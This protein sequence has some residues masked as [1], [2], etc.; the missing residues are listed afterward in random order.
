MARTERSGAVGVGGVIPDDVRVRRAPAGAD[1]ALNHSDVRLAGGIL[2]V[3][4]FLDQS[5][6]IAIGD[7]PPAQQP[8]PPEIVAPFGIGI[9]AAPHHRGGGAPRGEQRR[10]AVQTIEQP[11]H[12][13]RGREGD[14]VPHLGIRSSGEFSRTRK[15]KRAGRCRPALRLFG[16]A[17]L[18]QAPATSAV[19]IFRPGPMVLE[20]ASLRTYLPLAPDGLA[21]TT[22]STSASKFARRSSAG[23]DALPIPEW[24]IP[25]FSTRY[26]I[27]PPLAALT[28]PATSIVTV[29]S[30]GFG[31]RPFGPSTLPRR[32]TTPIIS[33]V[34]MQRSKSIVPPW[35]ISI[36]S[37][38]PTTSAP[39]ALAS[40]AF[41]PLANTPTRT[42]FPVPYGS[43]TTPRT[44]WS[45]WL[46]STPRFI[47]ISIVS[48][49]FA[50]ALALASAIA[51]STPWSFSR[52]TFSAFCYL[53]TNAMS[54]A[55]HHFEAHRAGGAFDDAGRRVDVV[56]VQVLHL[57]LGDR[58]QRRALDLARDDLARLLRARFE[59]RR[60]LDQEA[61]RRRLG[62]E[63]ERTVGIDGDHGRDRRALFE[64]AGRGVERLA[65]F[66]DVDAALAQSRAD[67]RRR[68]GGAGGHLQLDIA[69]NLLCH[70]GL[71]SL[72]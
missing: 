9:I 19:S 27:W 4:G 63:R 66:H 28:A 1:V 67:R 7:P 59:V 31:I 51:S 3:D 29:P 38:A 47:A 16:Y 42:V 43:V 34:A 35:T 23:N 41:A 69:G 70:G 11:Q 50:V 17:A 13:R 45:A 40:S 22:A 26:S 71:F 60:L 44:I 20:I 10:R 54:L 49:N 65:E 61:R 64:V 33:G 14:E 5:L 36:R 25:A 6:V 15:S 53:L 37:S 57:G 12:Q 58:G 52:S 2:V 46:G 21:L 68:I 62:L 72:Y 24:M 56:G 48:S 55:L 39:A 18:A 32:P 30:L 8:E